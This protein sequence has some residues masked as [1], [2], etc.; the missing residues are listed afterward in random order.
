MGGEGDGARCHWS[1]LSSES[2][3]RAPMALIWCH[4]VPQ[5]KLTVWCDPYTYSKENEKS[6]PAKE[7]IP[8][9]NCSHNPFKAERVKAAYSVC[10]LSVPVHSDKTLIC[11]TKCHYFH[12]PFQ[13]GACKKRECFSKNI[14]AKSFFLFFPHWKFL[15]VYSSTLWFALLRTG[16]AAWS[17]KLFL[18]Q[19]PW[20]VHVLLKSDVIAQNRSQLVQRIV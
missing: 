2:W 19:N 10:T 5:L 14:N 11:T 6:N 17:W 18:C 1:F 15:S 16:M 20:A 12:K 4:N 13:D 7:N 8:Q 9:A 3:F